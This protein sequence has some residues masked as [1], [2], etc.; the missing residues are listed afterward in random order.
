MIYRG[1]LAGWTYRIL[2]DGRTRGA[3]PGGHWACALA[4]A[5]L[6]RGDK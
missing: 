6:V 3:Q 2:D 1:A 5:V 4:L